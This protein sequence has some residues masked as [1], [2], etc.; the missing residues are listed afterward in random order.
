[1]RRASDAELALQPL[2]FLHVARGCQTL[3][4][5]RAAGVDHRDI[6]LDAGQVGA[7]IVTDA[8]PGRQLLR[9][10]LALREQSL[11]ARGLRRIAACGI[12]LTDAGVEVGDFEK[13]A[14]IRGAGVHA[15]N[16][17]RGICG[18][19]CGGPCR[20]RTDDIHGVNVAL[21]QLS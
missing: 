1:M 6:R 21:Y 4:V 10:L 16:L 7:Q 11:H 5:A 8:E 14:L 20:D 13:A 3:R 15:S 17:P 9:E 12:G 2:R 19:E 18:S